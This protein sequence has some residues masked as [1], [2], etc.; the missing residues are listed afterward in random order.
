MGTGKLGGTGHDHPADRPTGN[1]GRKS[2]EDVATDFVY[3]TAFFDTDLAVRHLV[4][5]S[6]VPNDAAVSGLGLTESGE[7]RR[8]L[9]YNE[10]T[11]F[12]I[13]PT[14]CAKTGSSSRG[15]YVRCTFDFHGIRSEAIGRGP[16]SGSY[17]ISWSLIQSPSG[18]IPMFR[19]IWRLRSSGLRCGI[20]S[21]IGCPQTIRRTPRSCTTP[22]TLN[23]SCPRSRSDSGSSTHVST[24]RRD[25]PRPEQRT[26]SPY[27]WSSPYRS[28]P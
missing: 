16:Y 13:I 3:E 18:R 12:Q 26:G 1:P 19:R 25:R 17:S 21:T 27:L 15:T 6:R 24:W 28:A 22:T 9:S 23:T 5:A 7:F 11:G 10:A 8:W 4:N 20:R 14:S 2:P